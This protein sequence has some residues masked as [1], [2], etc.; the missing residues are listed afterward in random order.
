MSFPEV[1]QTDVDLRGWDW[2]RELQRQERG[3]PWLARKTDTHYKAIYRYKWGHA[4]PPIEW[5]RAAALA[6]GKD[7]SGL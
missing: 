4:V 7:G 3:I 5:L 1:P 2:H 6:L